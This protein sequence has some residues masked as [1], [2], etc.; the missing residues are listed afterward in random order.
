MSQDVGVRIP[1]Q[2]PIILEG[3]EIMVKNKIYLVE[4]DGATAAVDTKSK[5]SAEKWAIDY[6]GRCCGTFKIRQISELESR[7]HG[8]IIH[9]LPATRTKQCKNI[10]RG[11]NIIT[12]T[13]DG[14]CGNYIADEYDVCD[15]CMLSRYNLDQKSHYDSCDREGIGPIYYTEEDVIDALRK[16]EDEG[17]CE[18]CED[19]G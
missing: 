13:V 14:E 15:R 8:V 19:Y 6:F 12:D 1:P 11:F 16:A 18:G 2:A 7:Q 5:R 9:T 3:C 17:W 10:I 4:F